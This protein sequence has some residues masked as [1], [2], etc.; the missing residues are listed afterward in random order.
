MRVR[1]FL[2]IRVDAAARVLN[3]SSRL[4]EA[5]ILLNR[6]R[7]YTAGPIVRDQ[8]ELAGLI[9]RH[10]ARHAAARGHFV[11]ECQLARALIDSERAH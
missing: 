5:A 1:T 6:K 11:E 7:G 4:S 8:E 2:A 3:K 9:D 10:V